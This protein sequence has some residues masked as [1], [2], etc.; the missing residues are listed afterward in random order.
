MRATNQARPP[1]SVDAPDQQRLKVARLEIE[2]LLA[3]HDLA[4]VCVLHT[5]G[6]SEFFYCVTPSYSVCWIDESAQAVRI[7]SALDRDHG[8]D[9]AEQQRMQIATA[10][11]T[12]SLTSALIDAAR[13]FIDVDNVVSEALRA[14]HSDSEFVPDPHQ[15]R[16]S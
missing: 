3:K 6:M 14:E 2:A 13:M 12:A 15:A 9:G 16:P 5:P 11:M 10:N 1:Y 4:G 7:E 8:G